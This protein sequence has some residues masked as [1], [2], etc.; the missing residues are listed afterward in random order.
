M[1]YI[2]ESNSRWTRLDDLARA[3]RRHSADYYLQ[4]RGDPG[5]S[6]A[7]YFIVCEEA[8]CSIEVSRTLGELQDQNKRR[9]AEARLIQLHHEAIDDDPPVQ[10]TAAE[11]SA[12]TSSD[13]AV[14]HR[15]ADR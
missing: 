15:P 7:P 2:G 4:G 13:G 14:G 6:S 10:K 1:F 12:T 3:R 8:G 11:A 5:H 9:A